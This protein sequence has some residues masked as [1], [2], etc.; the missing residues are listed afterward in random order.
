MISK[1]KK[2]ID[3]AEELASRGLSDRRIIDE[4]I[5]NEKPIP[6]KEKKN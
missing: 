3:R 4:I 6:K 2:T 5:R 1:N